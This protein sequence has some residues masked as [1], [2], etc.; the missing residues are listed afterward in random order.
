MDSVAVKRIQLLAT[1]ILKQ[2][3]IGQDYR[4]DNWK[5]GVICLHM[6]TP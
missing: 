3:N 6:N 1:T 5:R 2:N 4:Y